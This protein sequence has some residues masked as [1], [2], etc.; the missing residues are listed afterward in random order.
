MWRGMLKVAMA[1]ALFG[2]AHSVLAGTWAQERAT[3]LVGKRMVDG[4]YRPFYMAASLVLLAGIVVYIRRQPAR[5]VYHARGVL[6]WILRAVQV[7]AL[8]YLLWAFY[9]VGPAFFAGWDGATAWWQGAAELPAPPY[10][11]GPAP[12]G[13][14]TMRATGPFAHTRHPLNWGL[15]PLFW[16]APRLSTRRLA[17]NLAVTVYIVLGA[18]HAE[19]HLL[20]TYGPAYQQYQNH[21]PFSIG[22][23]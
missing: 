16:L 4:L 3:E 11:Q 6:A 15:L 20:A 19:Y 22:R 18:V 9:H 13:D 5:E 23:W 12:V 17:F 7:A 8:S 1:I 21:V 14:G 2:L 10:G